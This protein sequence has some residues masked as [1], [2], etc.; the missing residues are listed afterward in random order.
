[1]VERP[2]KKSE[3]QQMPETA[4]ATA[5]SEGGVEVQATQAAPVKRAPAPIIRDRS[6]DSE[7]DS[8]RGRDGGRDSD[9]SRGRDS[10]REGNRDRDRGRGKGGQGNRYE[11][12]KRPTS[13]ALMRGPKPVQPTAPVEEPPVEEPAPEE[14]AIEE[15]VVSEEAVETEAPVA[16]APVAAAES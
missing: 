6:K 14:L 10:S 8:D 16:E 1:M 13:M 4:A 2:I 15:A 11:E 3:R 5:G 9:R 12:E 7:Q